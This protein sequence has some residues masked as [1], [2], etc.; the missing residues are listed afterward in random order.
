M[1][2]V[3]RTREKTAASLAAVGVLASWFQVPTDV[4]VPLW[5]AAALRRA[6][7]FRTSISRKAGFSA[8]SVAWAA[9]IMRPEGAT[10][11]AYVSSST[12]QPGV[13][14][15]HA[16]DVSVCAERAGR[17]PAGDQKGTVEPRQPAL[18]SLPVHGNILLTHC[19]ST[20]TSFMLKVPRGL[21]LSILGMAQFLCSAT[22]N[23]HSQSNHRAIC[24][25]RCQ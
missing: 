2:P 18:D 4:K 23:L 13:F 7:A 5:K 20:A 8:S 14:L 3:Q 24:S 15:E 16:Q 9:N 22:R 11:S 25:R 6:A 1:T 19:R 12:V 10:S 21:D 17:Q